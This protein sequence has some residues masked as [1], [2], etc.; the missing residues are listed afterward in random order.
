MR[1]PLREDGH[2]SLVVDAGQKHGSFRSRQP[3]VGRFARPVWAIEIM[4]PTVAQDR[5]T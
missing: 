5:C 2:S 3:F 1:Q 4:R